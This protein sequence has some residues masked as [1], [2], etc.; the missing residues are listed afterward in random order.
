[1]PDPRF[2]TPYYMRPWNQ[3]FNENLASY[4]FDEVDK[5][6]ALRDRALINLRA[7]D[8]FRDWAESW[9]I[10]V[11]PNLDSIAP[12]AMAAVGPAGNV[13]V[14]PYVSR[15]ISNEGL[16]NTLAH[17]YTHVYDY[18]VGNDNYSKF[19]NGSFTMASEN[20]N[21]QSTS[22][23]F[24]NSPDFSRQFSGNGNFDYGKRGPG[25]ARN[26]YGT[27]SY[28]EPFAVIP[29]LY[30]KNITS[31]PK[32]LQAYYKDMIDFPKPTGMTE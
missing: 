14:S 25:M 8:R 6:K 3:N 21:F 12:G 10:K 18:L 5:L 30:E 16:Q 1:M 24:F 15:S 31:M 23:R 32:W 19:P 17:E 26:R 4:N 13:L 28:M 7:K 2:S 9:P 29:Q 20:P 22:N 27:D 11:S